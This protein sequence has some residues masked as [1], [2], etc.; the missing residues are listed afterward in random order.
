MS[1]TMAV[2]YEV[3]EPQAGY[4]TT[5]Q[6][7]AAGVSSRALH[8]RTRSGDINH[9]HYGL[10]RLRRFPAHPFEDVVAACLW[11]G[12][13]SVASHA[14]A[15]AV[16]GIS[17]AMPSQIHVTVSR[18]FRGHRD[19]VVVHRADLPDD[20]RIRVDS[21]SVTSIARTLQDVAAA[22]EPALVEQAVADAI[23]RDV[24][25]RQQLRRIVR[26]TPSL[27]PMVVGALVKE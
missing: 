16:H 10:Y 3:A 6:A 26:E 2:L 25:S 19:G 17:D 5:A 12:D 13:S 21:V 18:P 4:F 20:D 8:R 11:A 24:L 27:A 22:E 14:T 23:A 15:L 7:A 9:I 1:A